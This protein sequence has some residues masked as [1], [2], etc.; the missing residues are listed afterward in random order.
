MQPQS[1]FADGKTLGTS[2]Q[3]SVVNGHNN[4]RSD[5]D[6]KYVLIVCTDQR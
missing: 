6:T 5:S 3:C 2:K 1:M 4:D